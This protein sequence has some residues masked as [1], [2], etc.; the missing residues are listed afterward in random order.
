MTLEVYD[1]FA[2]LKKFVRLWYEV[3]E[4][5]LFH[6]VFPFVELIVECAFPG[7]GFIFS[8]LSDQ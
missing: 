7:T 4:S 6:L 2:D 3:D 8:I 1:L 5:I